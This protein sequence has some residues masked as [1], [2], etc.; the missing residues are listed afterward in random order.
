MHGVV[1]AGKAVRHKKKVV[2]FHRQHIFHF[3]NTQQYKIHITNHV[4]A[5]A[6]G[7]RVNTNMWQCTF[8]S[9]LLFFLEKDLMH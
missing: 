3:K 5:V 9:H 1:G 6:V 8:R 2:R 7:T 4:Y